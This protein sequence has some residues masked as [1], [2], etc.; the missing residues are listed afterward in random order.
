MHKYI[1]VIYSLMGRLVFGFAALLCLHAPARSEMY[2]IK[3]PADKIQNPA[4]KMYN[5]ATQVDNPA[6]NIYNPATRMN[7]PDPLSPPTQ[8][9]P[10][11]IPQTVSPEI[12]PPSKPEKLIRKVDVPPK[13]YKFKTVSEYVF[14]A[15]RAFTRDDIKEFLSITEDALKKIQSGAL[16]ASQS[17]KQ[18][19]INYKK[20]GYGLLEERK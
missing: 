17:T 18:K 19:L 10:P 2:S 8:A 20:F 11:P 14:A 12:V 15:K 4:D 16:N 3:N 1:V 5:P 7:N 9:I 6:A 13:S